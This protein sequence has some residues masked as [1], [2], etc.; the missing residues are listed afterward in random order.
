MS[1]RRAEITQSLRHALA[2]EEKTVGQL[3]LIMASAILI[4]LEETDHTP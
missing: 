4:L 2:S 3:M 1:P